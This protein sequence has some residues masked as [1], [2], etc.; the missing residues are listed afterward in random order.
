VLA[1]RGRPRL[2]WTGI[3]TA[4]VASAMLFRIVQ[5]GLL[6][7]FQRLWIEL[8]HRELAFLGFDRHPTHPSPFQSWFGPLGFLLAVGCLVLVL[9]RR[10]EFGR[11]VVLLA[12][13]PVI[14]IVLQG[15][16]TDYNLFDGRYVMFAVALAA[17]LWGLVLPF[18]P[19]AWAAA[20]IAVTTLML[21]FV[22]YDEKPSGVAVLGGPAPVSVWDQSRAE[23]MG[24]T[25]PPGQEPIVAALD[26]RARTGSVVA[27]RIRREDV[28]YPFFGER[29]DRRVEFPVTGEAVG[30]DWV[31][32]APGQLFPSVNTPIVDSHGWRLYRTNAAS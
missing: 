6:H 28:S 18:R 24:R 1:I 2:F 21:V 29:L 12:L 4:I 9:A 7:A 32:V 30:A 8:G 23:V 16:V 19:A 5:H 27:L 10:R 31:V 20:T 25:M 14:W 22:H 15:I 3:A 26:R 13:L 11:R 17:A